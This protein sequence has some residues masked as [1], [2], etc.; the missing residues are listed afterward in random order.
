MSQN[1]AGIKS[2]ISAMTR[3]SRIVRYILRM[4]K[5]FLFPPI[6]IYSVGKA[7]TTSIQVSLVKAHIMNPIFHTHRLSWNA[8][9]ESHKNFRNA[10]LNVPNHIADGKYLRF[11]IDKTRG[12]VR[13]KIISLTRDPIACKISNLFET[14]KNYPQLRNL[15]GDE[16][17]N[18]ILTHLEKGFNEYDEENDRTN[19]W[20]NL[21]LKDV[22]GFDVYAENFEPAAGY[23][24]TK[25]ENADILIIK[26]EDLSRCGPEA[27]QKFLGIHDFQLI[28]ANVGSE[29]S[30]KE[31]YQRVLNT[32][33]LSTDTVE[34]IYRSRYARQFYS[35]EEIN[36][37]KQ[38]W[39][40]RS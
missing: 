34:R 32:I 27:L 40:N 31:A 22:F 4:I 38:H 13:W 5:G 9:K 15:A 23:K 30:Y 25:A 12:K 6:L 24:I 7:G 35:E 26:L 28:K 8:L 20:F 21:E 39:A 10:G 19:N 17:V 16:L 11:F 3:F 1:H 33:S 14:L 29:K 36:I 37:F 18:G 2:I